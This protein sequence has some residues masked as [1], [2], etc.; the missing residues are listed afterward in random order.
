MQYPNFLIGILF[1][2]FYAWECFESYSCYEM[3]ASN[4]DFTAAL[5]HCSTKGSILT[6]IISSAENNFLRNLCSNNNCWI[7]LIE[8]EH[9]SGDA[10]WIDGSSYSAGGYN[11]WHGGEPN[12]WQGNDEPLTIMNLVIPELYIVDGTWF[13]VPGDFQARAICKKSYPFLKMVHDFYYGT[14]EQLFWFCNESTKFCYLIDY[15]PKTFHDA[16]SQCRGLDSTVTS[17]TSSEENDFI[18]QICGFYHCW[19]GLQDDS[20][21][22]EEWLDGSNSGYRNWHEGEPNDF[23]QNEPYTIMNIMLAEA[24]LLIVDGTWF[25][26]PGDFYAATICKKNMD[27][28]EAAIPVAKK[29]SR[30]CTPVGTFVLYVLLP[31]MV[32]S[33]V[34]AAI[35]GFMRWRSTSGLEKNQEDTGIHHTNE[36]RMRAQ[37]MNA[38]HV[39]I[40]QNSHQLPQQLSQPYN[41]QASNVQHQEG[42]PLVTYPQGTKMVPQSTHNGSAVN[43]Y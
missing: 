26:V 12:N 9:D 38:V 10:Y 5:Q 14:M 6:S 32:C 34:L 13:D 30:I 40:P 31:L 7:G 19:I 18:A 43:T 1:R 20:R 29:D 35:F 37:N 16:Q 2:T 39:P 42:V 27:E 33:C 21:G 8:K 28:A 17:I 3:S 23:G 11:N 36:G 25:D 15:T 24:Q 4:L 22:Y 41:V